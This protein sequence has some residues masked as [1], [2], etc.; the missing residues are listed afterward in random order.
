M[1]DSIEDGILRFA[2]NDVYA[3]LDDADAL[4]LKSYLLLSLGK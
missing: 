4:V 3:Q 1:I 2:Q